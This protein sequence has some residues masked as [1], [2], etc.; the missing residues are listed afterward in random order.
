MDDSSTHPNDPDNP[1][2]PRQDP[3]GGDESSPDETR[4]G[5]AGEQRW[6]PPRPWFPQPGGSAPGSPA[7][8]PGPHDPT[9]GFGQPAPQ[10]RGQGPGP[11]QGQGYYPPPRAG[12][13]GGFPWTPGGPGGPGSP[14]GPPPSDP[15]AASQ[16]QGP[17]RGARIAAR[18]RRPLVVVSGVALVAGLVGGGV[19]AGVTYGLTDHSSGPPLVN[20]PK[21]TSG[22]TKAAAGSTQRI[23]KQILP[24]VVSIQVTTPRGQAE[25]SGI[26][27][28]SDGKLL[29]NNHVVA[30]AARAGRITVSFNDGDTKQARIVGLD[31]K[32]DLAVVQVEDASG[33]TPATLGHSSEVSVGQQVLAVGSPFG[34]SGTVTSGIVSAKH[35]PVRAGSSEGGDR[36]T[37]IDAIQTDAPINPGN[38]GGPLVNMQGQVIGIDSAIFTPHGK[39]SVGLGFAI[40]IDEARPII[41]Q[42]ASTGTAS[43]ARLGVRVTDVRSNQGSSGT[44]GGAGIV[45]VQSGSAAAK[46]GLQAKD[47]AV[48]LNDREIDSADALIAAVRSHR[49]GDTVKLT[50]VRDGSTHTTKVTLG[51]DA[52]TT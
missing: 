48:K 29:T 49:P 10:P 3:A 15:Y 40:P 2:E 25:G 42:L 27:L 39:G 18:L 47:I 1:G 5:Q 21:G 31:A 28:S 32:T 36:S 17:S 11:G 6:A 43:H 26:V 16:P 33:L 12:E 52:T 22:A 34:L 13:P 23:S 8:Q 41:K 45:R 44:A 50:Y 46:A 38:S 51:S 9:S 19:G 14:G 20:A 4:P 7:A 35:R 24:S 37:V 30:P